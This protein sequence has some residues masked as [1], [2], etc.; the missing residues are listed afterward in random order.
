MK[1]ASYF[2]YS[3]LGRVG[4]SRGQPRGLAGYRMARDLAPGP[5]FRSVSPPLYVSRYR[6]EVLEQLEPRRTWDH[7]HHLAEGAEPVLLCFEKT[8]FHRERW[9]HRRLVAE[10]FEREL[11]EVVPE[12]SGPVPPMRDYLGFNPWG[13]FE[14]FSIDA[15]GRMTDAWFHDE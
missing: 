2:T 10:W 6:R 8:P 12:V 1:T 4:I 13:S 9:C 3:G 11:G 14:G 7:L 5:W 15:E